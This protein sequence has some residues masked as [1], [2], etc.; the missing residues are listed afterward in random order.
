MRAGYVEW[1]TDRSKI[2]D[3]KFG[4]P[5]GSIISPILS[6]LYL[7][8]LDIFIEGKI[9]SLNERNKDQKNP[10][11]KNPAYNSITLKIKR[12]IDKLRILAKDPRNNESTIKK[13]KKEIREFITLRRRTKSV[14][15]N[16]K[17]NPH[18]YYVRY[19]DD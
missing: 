17:Y 12:R 1:N 8:E 18:F 19:A 10:Y 7:H 2:L 16:P 11:I 6:N 3:L 4:V 13:N 5:Q 14:I 15:H 9:K